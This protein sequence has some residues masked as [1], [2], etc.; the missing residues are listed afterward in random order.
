MKKFSTLLKN[1]DDKKKEKQIKKA[2]EKAFDVEIELNA[3]EDEN[4]Y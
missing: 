3:Y 1:K 4:E 2:I